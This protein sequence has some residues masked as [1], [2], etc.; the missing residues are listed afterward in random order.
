MSVY[1][2]TAEVETC[3]VVKGNLMQ[4]LTFFLTLRLQMQMQRLWKIVAINAV[5]CLV[6]HIVHFKV[7]GLE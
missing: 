2:E 4:I 1:Y 3:A 7:P 6:R 5:P